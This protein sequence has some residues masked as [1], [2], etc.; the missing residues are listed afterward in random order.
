M[1]NLNCFKEIYKN[2]HSIILIFRLGINF[3]IIVNNR[4]NNKIVIIVVKIVMVQQK[5][6][7]YHALKNHQEYIYKNI[8]HV[9]VHMIIMMIKLIRIVNHILIYN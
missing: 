8:K 5:Q 4:L 3:F 2:L 1:Y 6:I 9:F 7:V